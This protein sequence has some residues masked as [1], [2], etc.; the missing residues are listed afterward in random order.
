M[1]PLTFSWQDDRLV[2]HAA[3]IGRKLDLIHR[4]GRAAFEI[5]LH[6]EVV[7]AAQACD[8]TVRFASLV[9]SGPIRILEDEDEKGRALEVLMRHNRHTGP[10]EI[11]VAAVRGTAVFKL[12]IEEMSGKCN[13]LEWFSQV[14]NRNKDNDELSSSSGGGG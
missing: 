11:P 3:R 13:D 1:V 14:V 2:F 9:G 7:V 5:D 12:Q 8:W 6:S 10:L 4:K